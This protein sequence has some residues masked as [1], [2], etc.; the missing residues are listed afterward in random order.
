MSE[1]KRRDDRVSRGARRTEARTRSRFVWLAGALVISASVVGFTL[2]QSQSVRAG[3]SPIRHVVVIYQENHSFDNVLGRVCAEIASGQIVGHAPCDGAT[4]GRTS[5]GLTLPL[6]T[7]PDVVPT[8]AHTVGTQIKDINGGLM[9]GFDTAGGCG[10]PSGYACYTQFDPA[11]IPN[12]AALAEHFVISDRTFEYRATPSWGGHMLLASAT[13]DGFVGDNP[14]SNGNNM[15]WGCDSGLLAAWSNGSQIL[16][17]PSC[18]PNAQGQGP[19]TSSPV[20][21]VPT[22]FDRLDHAGLSWKIYGGMGGPG[23]GYGW[24]ICP[25]FYEC[26]GSSQRQSLVAAGNVLSAANSGNLPN[27]AI[28]TPTTSNSQHNGKSMLQGDNW[29]GSVVSAIENGPD[30]ASTAIFITYDDCGCFYDHVAPPIAGE[31]VRVPM[32]I[33]SPYARPGYTDST[34]ATLISMLTYTENVFGLTPLNASDAN[35]Y[36][37]ANAFNYHQVPAPP[38]RMSNEQIPLSEQ[39]YIRTHPGNTN[40]PT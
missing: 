4:R 23:A 13:L 14:S 16:Q 37:Y 38:A 6:A 3:S 7:S 12:L 21:Y 26:L 19:F 36:N 10:V 17:V 29:L 30:W 40:D 24:T 32:V 9:N 28:V 5:K 2:T 27:F 1:V 39:Q 34:D 33:V 31:G 25:T 20:P 35:A 18:I 8:V 11:Q 22:I 15:G